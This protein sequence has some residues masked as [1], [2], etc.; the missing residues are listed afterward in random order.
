M[1]FSAGAETELDEQA[2]NCFGRGDA[3]AQCSNAKTCDM[4]GFGDAGR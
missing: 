1:G 2:L 3:T 4:K